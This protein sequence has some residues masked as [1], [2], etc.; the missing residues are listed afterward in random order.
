MEIEI[1]KNIFAGITI[2][3]GVIFPAI[4]I[5]KIGAEAMKGMARNPEGASKIQTSMILSFAFLE[6]IAIYVLLIALVIKFG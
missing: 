6:A 3:L 1:I 2:S 5:G 4:S